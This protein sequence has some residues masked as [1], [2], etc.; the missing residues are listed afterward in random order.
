MA[1]GCARHT[2]RRRLQN[3]DRPVRLHVSLACENLTWYYFEPGG[4]SVKRHVPDDRR[5]VQP[6]ATCLWRCSMVT[7]TPDKIYELVERFNRGRRTYTAPT[8]NETQVRREFI[9]PLFA[10]L[11]WDIDNTLGYADAYKDVIHED[12]LM[13]GGA[14]KAPDYSFRVGGVRKFF[15]EAKKPSINLHD[16]PLPA[17]QLRRYAWNAKLPLSVVTDF[18]EFAVYDCRHQ[19]QP[20][21]SVSAHRLLYVRADEYDTRWHEIADVF[22]KEAVLRGNFDDY[23][24]AVKGKRGTTEV[25]RIFLAEMEEWRRLLAKNFMLRN[26]LT[27]PELNFAVQQ[28]IDRIVFLRI[29]EDRGIES[30]GELQGTLSSPNIYNELVQIFKRADDRYNSGLFHFRAERGR[31][32]A[33]DVLTPELIIDNRVLKRVI[34]LLYYPISPYDFR[35]LPLDILGQ[36]YERFLGQVIRL[37]PSGRAVVEPKPQVRKAGGVYYTPTYIVE[38]IVDRTLTP[39]LSKLS[40]SSAS[41]VRIIDPASGSGSFLLVAFD[42]LLKWHLEFYQNSKSRTYRSRIYQGA[43][44]RY[45][46]TV[47]EKRRILLNNIFGVDIDSTHRPSR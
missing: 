3:V 16:D 40:P 22:S 47:D 38:H 8:Y 1:D 43:G 6:A 31:L 19:P 15:V 34:K 23:A 28:T 20:Q 24:V 10:A 41:R 26:S 32:D 4:E 30:Y 13:I 37:T 44:G 42:R 27:Q 12:R 36:I 21:D 11:G 25:D 9:D 45:Y 17:Y 33:P 7:Q 39:I 18:D 14:S 5:A 46:L 2:T 29:C 35:I